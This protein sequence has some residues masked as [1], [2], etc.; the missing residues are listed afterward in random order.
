[1]NTTSNERNAKRK[2]QEDLSGKPSPKKRM[3]EDRKSAS[4][5]NDTGA[6]IYHVHMPAI[7]QEHIPCQ[8][9]L[10]NHSPKKFFSGEV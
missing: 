7:A 9:A 8:L 5:D 3:A 6:A 4:H 10:C 2:S 1:M